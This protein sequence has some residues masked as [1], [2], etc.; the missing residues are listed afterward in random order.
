MVLAFLDLAARA[1]PRHVEA[2]FFALLMSVINVG[3]QGA[4]VVG[5]YLYDWIGFTPLI[6]ISAGATTLA[7]IRVP[8]VGIDAIE[9]R[10]KAGQ[11]A[12]PARTLS[13]TT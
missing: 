1:C 4:K 7:W 12:A 3:N 11:D 6:F 9:A 13:A 2:T 5:G 8:F 10:A